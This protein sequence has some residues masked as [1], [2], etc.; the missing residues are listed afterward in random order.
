MTYEDYKTLRKTVTTRHGEFAYIDVGDGPAVMFLHGLFVSAYMWHR[1]I[2]EVK[3]ERRCIA[4]NLPHHGGSEVDDD[5]EL[6]LDANVEML[7]GF[8]D[9]L[10][11]DELDIVANDTGGAFAQGF[12]VRHPDR[13]RTL[14][15]TNCEARDWMPSHD[16]LAQLVNKLASD[17]Q[18]APALKAG[19]DDIDAARKGPFA[20]PYQ[21]PERLSDEEIRGIMEPHQA[22]LEGGR[23]LERFIASLEPEQLAALE[24]RLRELHVPTLAVWGTADT[25][26]PL[27]LAHWLRDTIPGCDEVVEIEGGKL[28][29]PFE[30][31]EELVPHLRRHWQQSAAAPAASG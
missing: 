6:T 28:F 3:A 22:T 11:L 23:R 1:V 31:G 16:E 15:L 29:W 25:V 19:C 9:A 17:G 2:D 4:L 14:T 12:A 5:Q 20:A 24:P 8:C 27:E 18:L 26:F 13:V 10:G 21:W 7:E 30:R